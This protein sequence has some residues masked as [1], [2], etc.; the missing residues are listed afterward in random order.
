M[1]YS[2]QVNTIS[3]AVAIRY[4]CC[5]SS[6]RSSASDS[7]SFGCAA[8]E[9]A[10]FPNCPTTTN[11][12]AAAYTAASPALASAATSTMSK[13]CMMICATLVSDRGP[14]NFQKSR[15]RCGVDSVVVG[16]PMSVINRRHHSHPS[17]AASTYGKP[18]AAPSAMFEPVAA[19]TRTNASWMS[20][21]LISSSVA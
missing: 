10:L 6:C 13:R 20:G 15:R 16:V 9:I 12:V 8:R 17:T 18:Q 4:R 21:R 14:L 2:G 7:A 1:R 11:R 19:T 3:Q 5:A